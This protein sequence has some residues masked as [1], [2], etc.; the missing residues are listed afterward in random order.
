MKKYLSLAVMFVFFSSAG[1][2][3]SGSSEDSA[4]PTLP[5]MEEIKAEFPPQPETVRVQMTIWNYVYTDNFSIND[6]YLRVQLSGRKAFDHI[7]FSGQ[8]ENEYLSGRIRRSY[9]GELFFSADLTNL[10]VRKWGNTYTVS[11]TTGFNNEPMQYVDFR[12]YSTGFGGFTISQAGMYLNASAQTIS[13]HFDA[14][15]YSKRVVASLAVIIVSL[16]LKLDELSE[17]AGK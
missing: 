9:D 16:Q 4:L 15:R 2:S 10:M 14:S 11:G 12:I 17:P 3:F 1:T 6:P 13:G 7:D 8:V 5:T